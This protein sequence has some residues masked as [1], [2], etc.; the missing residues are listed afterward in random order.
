MTNRYTTM[1]NNENFRYM[2][3]FFIATTLL[4][5]IFST[6][7][8]IYSQN[9]TSNNTISSPGIKSELDEVRFELYTDDLNRYSLD[10]PSNWN[11]DKDSLGTLR[12]ESPLENETD[13]YVDVILVT[14]SNISDGFNGSTTDM[15]FNGLVNKEMDYLKLVNDFELIES[16][17]IS[18][19]NINSQAHKFVYT[20]SDPSIGD[21]KALDIMIP[22]N[23][24]I[25]YLSYITKPMDFDKNIKVAQKV[26]DSFKFTQEVTEGNDYL[27][28]DLL[29]NLNELPNGKFDALKSFDDTQLLLDFGESISSS[30][31]NNT[32]SFSALGYSLVDNIKV[33]GAKI[34]DNNSV[35][36]TLDHDFTSPTNVPSVTVVVYKIDIDIR[37]LF[38]FLISD[39]SN[40][41]LF[42][43][44]NSFQFE[45][46]PIFDVIN[47]FKI[48]SNVI[49]QGWSSPVDIPIKVKNGEFPQKGTDTSIVL[50]QVIPMG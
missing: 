41:D 32:S 13:P 11:I 25:Y 18:L 28:E 15:S 26:F 35:N 2:F 17:N 22:H 19:K 42:E 36:V 48:G 10:Y 37:D 21:A 8:K 27:S 7:N 43:S 34:V 29:S 47:N 49:G 20:Y 44:R 40:V 9:D 3:L 4:L 1:K 33:I 50:I 45:N 12:I 38:S 14:I 24:E 6:D 16:S 30:I 39:A 5:V 31:F 46:I 23:N